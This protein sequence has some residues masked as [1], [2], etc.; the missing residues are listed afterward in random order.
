MSC[1]SLGIHVAISRAPMNRFPSNLGCRCFLSCKVFKTLK[2][3]EKVFNDVVTSVL[4]I[5]GWYAVGWD[6]SV[7]LVWYDLVCLCLLISIGQ[8]TWQN[9]YSVNATA[10]IPELKL[11]LENG[12]ILRD[13]QTIPSPISYFYILYFF[14]NF[15]EHLEEDCNFFFHFKKIW[16]DFPIVD[17]ILETA[18][19]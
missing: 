4:Y 3:K 8:I 18:A 5:Y 1:L 12:V 9:C 19:H 7:C 10:Y 2:C 11:I 14:F 6:A 15:K 17:I 16:Q 13:P